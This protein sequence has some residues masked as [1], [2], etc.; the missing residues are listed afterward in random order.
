MACHCCHDQLGCPSC[1]CAGHSKL[2]SLQSSHACVSPHVCL[3]RQTWE[4]GLWLDASW[5]VGH[6]VL[7]C[8]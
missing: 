5:N 1:S 8:A 4:M 6:G 7:L 3:M 2:V